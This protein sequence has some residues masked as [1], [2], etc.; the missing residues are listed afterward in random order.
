MA[1]GRR[2]LTDFQRELIRSALQSG[3]SNREIARD[4]GV[5]AGTVSRIRNAEGILPKGQAP[6]YTRNVA[7]TSNLLRQLRDTVEQKHSAQWNAWSQKPGHERG[8]FPP[9]V[10]RQI[11]AINTA[12]GLPKDAGAGYAAMWR[13]ET[14]GMFL[15]DAIADVTSQPNWREIYAA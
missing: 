11:E 1:L 3:I 7:F 6:S 4:L 9:D 15:P 10:Q 14:Q 12:L 2:Q 5:S 13:I 8:E